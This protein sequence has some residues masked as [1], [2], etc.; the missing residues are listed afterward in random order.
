MPCDWPWRQQCGID[1]CQSRDWQRRHVT[2]HVIVA[3]V[4]HVIVNVQM[5]DEN[6]FELGARGCAATLTCRGARVAVVGAVPAANRRA[7]ARAKQR[8]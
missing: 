7:Q 3:V 1:R 6:E 2:N 5:N 4:A 8:D